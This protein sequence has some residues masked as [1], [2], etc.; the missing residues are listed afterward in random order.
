M[1]INYDQLSQQFPQLSNALQGSI[2]QEM[3][4]DP[5]D[6]QAVASIKR[7]RTYQERLQK[8]ADGGPGALT[9]MFAGSTQQSELQPTRQ[10]ER[11]QQRQG[12]FLQNTL[13][14]PYD[15]TVSSDASM[16]DELGNVVNTRNAGYRETERAIGL[17]TGKYSEASA[18]LARLG[19]INRDAQ[20]SQAIQREQP[21]KDI[22]QKILDLRLE[23]FQAESIAREKLAGLPPS[24]RAEALRSLYDRYNSQISE[25]KDI[26][27]AR[28]S[29]FKSK[30][31]SD[32]DTKQDQ[33]DSLKSER[34]GYKEMIDTLE[35]RGSSQNALANF[36]LSALRTEKNLTKVTKGGGV[37]DEVQ[38]MAD[39]LV[40]QDPSLTRDRAL[41]IARDTKR[42][43]KTGELGDVN[44]GEPIFGEGLQAVSGRIPS[45]IRTVSPVGTKAAYTKTRQI[46]TLVNGGTPIESLLNMGYTPDDVSAAGYEP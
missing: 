13:Q 17:A 27:E 41:A 36:R 40:A 7:S 2:A 19:T 34:D 25:F 6:M 14:N 31:N 23:A 24:Y 26:R 3:G 22:D 28:L 18:R 10:E 5:T 11:V 21:T 37:L 39:A 44:L 15:T 32:I 45:D 20:I 12:R 4:I 9:N 35:K 8:V 46:Q 42:R 16:T 33:I 1:A 38:V 29:S 30:I 43:Q